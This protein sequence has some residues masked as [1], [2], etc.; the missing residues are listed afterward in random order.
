MSDDRSNGPGSFDRLIWCAL[1][2]LFRS[3]ASLEA[4]ILALHQQLNVLN[5]KSP[6][7]P[8]FSFRHVSYLKTSAAYTALHRLPYLLA[9]PKRQTCSSTSIKGTTFTDRR[10]EPELC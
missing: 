7:Q 3:R 9:I 2:G 4:E 5:R 6:E 8:I 1:I 10:T